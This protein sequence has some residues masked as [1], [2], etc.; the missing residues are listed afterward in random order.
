MNAATL[1]VLNNWSSD[2]K[3]ASVSGALGFYPEPGEYPCIMENIK[4]TTGTFRG[5][6]P[7]EFEIDA[8]VITFTLRLTE[9]PGSSSEPR[10][11][12]TEDIIIPIRPSDIPDAAKN[13]VQRAQIQI[14]TLKRYLAVVLGGSE[15]LTDDP[16]ADLMRAIEACQNETIGVQVLCERRDGKYRETRLL[17]RL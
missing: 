2:Y 10:A 16:A 11:F 5:K 14:Q 15:N 17:R 1:Q 9:D 13:Q 7:V 6:N 3:E 8:N 4:L 12:D